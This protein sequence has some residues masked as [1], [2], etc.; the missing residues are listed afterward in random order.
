MRIVV[1]RHGIA[2]DRDDPACPPEA[3]RALTRGGA[4]K[5]KRSARG[6][7][8]LGVLPTRILTSPYLRALQ[9]ATRTAAALKLPADVVT[10]TDAL[11]PG[12]DPALA[13]RELRALGDDDAMIVGHAPHLDRFIALLI[14]S[15]R[16][17]VTAL[18][19]V[20]A[21]C[22]ELVPGARTAT[23][24]WLLTRRHLAAIGAR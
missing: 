24:A 2:H 1:L 7:A 14:G 13:A 10:V 22:L 11:L 5:L 12:A 4:R 20:G 6:L 21:A 9:T 19:K 8:V 16:D 23:L 18:E 15:R 17:D 3:A